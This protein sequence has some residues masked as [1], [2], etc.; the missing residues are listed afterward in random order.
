MGGVVLICSLQHV[1]LLSIKAP[2]LRLWQCRDTCQ[3]E[4]LTDRSLPTVE[5]NYSNRVGRSDG[6]NVIITPYLTQVYPSL[7]APS[8][9]QPS[10]TCLSP[11]L[12][13]TTISGTTSCWL[14]HLMEVFQ[15]TILIWSCSLGVEYVKIRL[16]GDCFILLLVPLFL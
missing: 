3:S 8:R 5:T 11:W 9:S 2:H 10:L 14:T 13:N 7:N 16:V 12:Q 6:N 4:A 1:M 15:S